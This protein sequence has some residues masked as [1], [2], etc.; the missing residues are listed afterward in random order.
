MQTPILRSADLLV[1][2]AGL[3]G[4]AAAR[5][6]AQAGKRVLIL[7]RRTYP[8][9]EEGEW[10]R[11]W[12]AVPPQGLGALACWFPGGEKAAPGEE[13]P[14]VADQF[15]LRAEDLLLE[16]GAEFLYAV[17]PVAFRRTEKGFRVLLGSKSGLQ[18]VDAAQ[19]LDCSETQI[20]RALSP[21]SPEE[22]F[23]LGTPGETAYTA[24]WA[25]LSL[26]LGE[27]PLPEEFGALGNKALVHAS[28]FAAENR[29]LEF[30]FSRSA[31]YSR[32]G[33]WQAERQAR[34]QALAACRWLSGQPAFSG[35]R[36]GTLSW[37][38]APCGGWD[39]LEAL[40]LGEAVWEK[41]AAGR[42]FLRICLGEKRQASPAGQEPFPEEDLR[43]SGELAAYGNYPAAEEPLRGVRVGKPVDVA[44][45]GGGTSGAQ[46]ARAAAEAGAKTLLLDMNPCLGGTGTA[47]GVHYYWYGRRRGFTRRLDEEYQALASQFHYPKTFYVWGEQDDWNMDLK[48]ELLLRACEEAG[49]A[50]CLNSFTFAV[51]RREDRVTGV[52]A[53]TP[54]GPWY[55]PAAVT[56]DAT[57]DGDAALAAGAK[58]IYG[59]RRDRMTMWSCMAQYKQAGLYRGG[60]FTTSA[61]VGDL[62]DYTRYLLVNRRRGAEG[63]FDH[64]AYLA[65]R[66]TRHVEGDV[67]VTTRDVALGRQYEDA[68][69]TCFSNFD[70]KGKSN[71][72]LVYFGYLPPQMEMDVP[73]RASIPKGLEGLLVTGKAIS[74]TH[75]ALSGLRMQDD[76]QNHG[77]AVGLA[78]AMASRA[79]S[80][81]RVEIPALRERLRQLGVL[82]APRPAFA[83]QHPDLGALIR[84]LTGEE[85]FETIDMDMSLAEAS[86]S[87]L[88][89]LCLAERE[90]VLP[91]LR[92]AY[93]EARGAKRFL[94][95]RLLLWHRD[96]SGLEEILAELSRQLEEAEGL[97]RRTHSVKFCQPYPDHGVMAEA[98]YLVNELYKAEDPRILPLLERLV[99]RV[100]AA[101]RDWRD[102]RECVFSH[103]ESVAYVAERR[104][105][106]GYRPLLA[107]LLALPEFRQVERPAGAPGFDVDPIEERILYA[108]LIL[109]RALAR[110]GGREGYQILLRLT[111]DGRRLVAKSA[112]DE[113]SALTGAPLDSLA[114]AVA[115]LPEAPAPQP[116][117]EEIW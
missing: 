80:V 85:P 32:E 66:E 5:L 54:Y 10:K 72:D 24:E 111:E 75:D 43:A 81:R 8:G 44:V 20:T 78:A 94:L 73:Y 84:N 106:A 21:L 68:I 69:V 88:V 71:A 105:E 47:G 76:L 36:F 92:E 70:T 39:P 87:P 45:C 86:A 103:I 49:A 48:A 42:R 17:Q 52:L 51:T 1:V 62:F 55:F 26:P 113:L 110:C 95:A 64:G 53:A 57:G 77:G 30:R 14:F 90:E 13:L 11:P 34:G 37:Q 89:L 46:A 99:S 40:R 59:S 102:Q 74:A 23:L 25:G 16:A 35:A 9:Y 104:G 112:M 2:E 79:G 28:A 116:W 3:A 18:A 31:P 60:I 65:P 117:A 58:A 15:K 61:D 109:A 91:L 114:A 82:P 7:D 96:G 97:P 100:E 115:S 27:L 19:V 50:L 38:G 12:A 101:A 67:V 108:K 56:V 4:L 22:E 83:P 63:A 6:A 29:I 41:L 107:R 33:D 93:R 98:T